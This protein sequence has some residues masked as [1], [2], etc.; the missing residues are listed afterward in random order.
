MKFSDEV[1]EIFEEAQNTS[2]GLDWDRGGLSTRTLSHGNIELLR[3]WKDN[4]PPDVMRAYRRQQ[5]D[6]AQERG[7][8]AAYRKT[9]AYKAYRREYFERNGDEI[10]RKARERYAAKKAKKS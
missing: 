1:S 9:A 8:Y 5:N 3:E 7:Y 4:T 6:R 10:R 2:N